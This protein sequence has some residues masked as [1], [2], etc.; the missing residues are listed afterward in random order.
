MARTIR[1]A[2]L[3]TRTARSR[4]KSRGKPYW[5]SI[6][7]GLHLGYRK[8][9][10]G[11]RWV[12]R[13]YL[14]DEQYRVETLDGIADDAQDADGGNVLSY[15]QA[16][17]RAR[18]VFKARGGAAA[19]P[20][21]IGAA[22]DEYQAD[23][24][25]RDGDVN[26]VSRL[27][28][29]LPADW[30]KRAV[31]SLTADELKKWRNELRKTMAAASIN[32]VGNSLRALLNLAADNHGL[33]E[34]PWGTGLASIPGATQSNNVVLNEAT[35]RAIV[36]NSYLSTMKG[37]EQIKDDVARRKVEE[38]ARQFAAAFGLFVEICAITGA[39]PIQVSRLTVADLPEQGEPRL[40]MPSSKKGKGEKKIT[41]RPVPISRDLMVRLRE[42][43]GDRS[44][45]APLLIKPSGKLWGKSD[46]TRPFARAA[47]MAGVD[48]D[49]VS[50]YALR[51]SSIVRQIKANV[52]LRIIA[53]THDTSVAM[54]ERHYSECITDHADEM[55]RA[56]MLDFSTP[57]EGNLVKM[58]AR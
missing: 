27:R 28:G 18:E 19:A 43:A 30:L 37:A 23:L 29:H 39:R 38:E 17:Q 10:T 16:Q 9:K 25:A 56:A 41:R 52:P 36:A 8:G 4:L 42:T 24:A 44:G 48:P 58:P 3:E 55:T 33:K 5:R 53:A 14:G 57:A 34:R 6:D 7:P 13:F 11:G 20:L 31:A 12:A 50:I 46:H 51:H 22:L 45:K 2:A 54:I 26:N 21:T 35:V 49:E 32:R 47:K 1:D 15:V 40:M